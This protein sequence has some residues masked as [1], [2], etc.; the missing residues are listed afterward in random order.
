MSGWAQG[1][2]GRCGRVQVSTSFRL[3]LDVTS[4]PFARGLCRSVL[5]HLQVD[6]AM[7]ED[8][9]LAVTEACAN[10][11]EHAAAQDD[12]EVTVAIDADLCRITVADAGSGFDATL[13]PG[14]EGGSILE[15][16]R[17]IFLMRS[18]VDDLQFTPGSRGGT[19]VQLDKRL[20]VADTSPLRVLQLA[21]QA[22]L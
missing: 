15:N 4:V 11:V 7:I 10:V 13:E 3:P 8:I 19:S 18:L 6:P 5:Q 1:H 12:Y 17:G 14:D 20:V 22:Q 2:G 9:A 16:G 21:Q